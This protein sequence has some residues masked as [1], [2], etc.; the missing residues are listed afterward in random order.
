LNPIEE[1]SL[2][3]VNLGIIIPA[4]NCR[5]TIE[6]TL[7]SLQAIER[8]WQHVA[9]LVICDDAST[10]DTIAVIKTT[11][12]NRCPLRLLCHETNLGEGQ[13]YATMAASLPLDVNWFLILHADDLAE[14]NFLERNIDIARRCCSRVAAVSS[15][16]WVF[17]KGTEQ[18]ILGHDP[19]EDVI[20]WR[21]S[22]HDEIMH[23][24]SVGT[25]WHISGALVNR[26]VWEKLGGRDPTLPQLGDWDLMLRWQQ[27]GYVVGHGLIPTTKYRIATGSVSSQSYLEFR[28]IRERTLIIMR[29]PALF[30]RKLRIRAA[31]KLALQAL[32][33]ILKLILIGKPGHAL[34]GA[35]LSASCVLT[36]AWAC[37]SS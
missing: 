4:F 5:E 15:N 6:E 11:D 7:A 18:L 20:V 1:D 21:G 22:K 26:A 31:V 3:E 34:R 19:A 2:P 13:C 37:R 32:R 36:L 9:E 25:W 16:Y 14:K 24:V 17:G 12:F 23:T 10:D 33:R 35:A 28:D 29:H 8:G 30:T 27:N